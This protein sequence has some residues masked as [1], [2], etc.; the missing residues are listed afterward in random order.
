MS[1]THPPALLGNRPTA[2]SRRLLHRAVDLGLDFTSG[3]LR[4]DLVLRHGEVS[5]LIDRFAG[6]LPQDGENDEQLLEALTEIA[7]WSISQADPRYLAFPDTGDSIAS[8]AAD[9]VASFLNQNLIAFD[10][11]APAASVIEAQLI[12]WLRELVGYDTTPLADYQGLGSLGGMWTS[13]GNMSNHIAIAAALA[14]TYPEIRTTGMRALPEQPVIL[15]ASGV[16]HFSYLAA[17]QALGLGTDGLLWADATP[18]FTSDPASVARLMASPPPGKRIFMVVGVAGNCRTT[19]IDDLQAL[20]ELSTQHNVWFHVDACHGGSLLFSEK[21]KVQL[22]G[23][24]HADSIA[25]D[26][27]KGLFVSYPSSY[28]L[29]R[30]PAAIGR[31]ARYPGRAHDPD[32]LDLGLITPF[33]GSRGFESLKLW[34][35]IK[36]QGVE[37]IGRLV[38]DRQATFQKMVDL[39]ERTGCFRMLGT[40]DFY[41]CAFVFLPTP[42][43]E[44]LKQA[45][46]PTAHHAAVRDLISHYTAAFADR[47][48]RAGT[49]VFDLFALQDLADRLG[50]GSSAKYQVMGMC[51]GHPHIPDEI[52]HGIEQDI[53]EAAHELTGR[54]L[55]DLRTLLASANPA[56]STPRPGVT[57]PAGW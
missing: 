28:V 57:G 14:H 15:L 30:D 56:A 50:L 6:P 52:E 34:A 24:E 20:A 51:V 11:S 18:D 2:D 43:A 44:A 46:L 22:A 31:F 55:E 33:Y 13:G 21:L 45:A 16:E 1:D 8:L 47:L 19:G 49:V 40:S 53:I 54:M 4:D 10:R 38:E 9:I 3:A 7:R 29:F 12:T 26:P 25:L 37:G 27:H 42:V 17:A 32:C 35:L 36:H 23:I 48:Y 5:E 39:L 41:R